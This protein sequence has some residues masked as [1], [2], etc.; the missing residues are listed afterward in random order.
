ME[1]I[2]WFDCLYKIEVNYYLQSDLSY[3]TI[4]SKYIIQLF[5]GDSIWKI[6]SEEEKGLL[7]KTMALESHN[8][9]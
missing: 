9:A 7:N 6:P 8:A 4:F 3:C 5:R 1:S 2:A